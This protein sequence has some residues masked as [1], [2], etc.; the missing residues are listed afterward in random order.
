MHHLWCIDNAS[1]GNIII[2]VMNQAHVS[3]QIFGLLAIE[4]F[5]PANYAIGYADFTENLSVGKATET[6]KLGVCL[7]SGRDLSILFC[8]PPF[9]RVSTLHLCATESQN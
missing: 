4:Q 6:E 9:P 7:Y 2:R 8:G 5:G 1:K 3:Y